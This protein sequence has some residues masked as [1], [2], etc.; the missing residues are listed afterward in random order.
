MALNPSKSSNLEQLA[1]NGLT[2][3]FCTSLG[4]WKLSC[5]NMNALQELFL[6][7]SSTFY[8]YFLFTC[9]VILSYSDV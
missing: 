4:D 6:R 3:C 8:L 7:H 9:I 1:L 5:F 2:T